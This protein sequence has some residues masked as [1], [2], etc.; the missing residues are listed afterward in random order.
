MKSL[1]ILRKVALISLGTALL[2]QLHGCATTE[3]EEVPQFTADP[4]AFEYALGKAIELQILIEECTRLDAE[5]EPVARDAQ[6]AW[7][8]RNWP[9]VHVADT[10]YSAK[11]SSNVIE[12]NNQELSLVAVKYYNDTRKKVVRSLDASRRSYSNVIA[13]CNTRLGHYSSGIEDIAARNLNADMYLKSLVTEPVPE[14]Y[15]VPKLSG[16]MEISYEPGRS[17]YNIE[18]TMHESQC[19]DGQILTLRNEW[20]YEVYGVY[21]ENRKTIFIACVWGNCEVQE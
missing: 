11:L 5:F 19:K 15:D 13:R 16:T 8:S 9:Q 6:Q 7:Y 14:P 1:M 4:M 20:P 3:K 17:Q 2:V 10:E 18:R 21:C 12:Y